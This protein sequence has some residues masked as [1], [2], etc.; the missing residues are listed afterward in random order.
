MHDTDASASKQA[1]AEDFWLYFEYQVL[2]VYL[3]ELFFHGPRRLV[4][5]LLQGRIWTNSFFTSW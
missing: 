1:A 4:A 5:W 2:D 3:E